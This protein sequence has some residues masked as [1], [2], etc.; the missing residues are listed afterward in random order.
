M[1]FQSDIEKAVANGRIRV[2]LR[3]DRFWPDRV[4]DQ[5]ALSAITG[6]GTFAE[7]EYDDVLRKVAA[8]PWG[9]GL[10]EIFV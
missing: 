3:G 1:A 5:A 2:K 8:D 10:E 4:E 9:L 6:R 7:D